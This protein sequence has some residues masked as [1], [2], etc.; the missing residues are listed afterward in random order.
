MHV[1]LWI[2]G[3][4]LE[5][6]LRMAAD[7]GI[8]IHAAARKGPRSMQVRVYAYQAVQF[9]SLCEQSG[10]TCRT[11]RTGMLTRLIRLLR[12]RPMLVPA[13]ALA[14]LLV[15]CSSQMILRIRI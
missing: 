11:V 9:T 12:A 4:N 7:A 8:L 5:R 13:M 15:F 14:C 2:E 3:M 6:L 10:W 1:T